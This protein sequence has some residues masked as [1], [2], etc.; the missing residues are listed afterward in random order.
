MKKVLLLLVALFVAYNLS[1]IVVD[2]S[3]ETPGHEKLA[4]EAQHKRVSQLIA[5]MLD[6]NHYN[7]IALNDSLSSEIFDR[8]LADLDY[9]KIY[10]LAS[11]V[12]SFEKYRD[13]FDDFIPSGYLQPAY[14]I[15]D[16]YEERVLNRLEYINK[17]LE[18]E[19]DFTKDEYY[20]I[21][22]DKAAWME[23]YAELDKEWDK[24]LK[25]EALRLKLAGKEWAEIV[26][27]LK[28]RYENIQRR[29]QQ[30]NSEDVFQIYMNAY[31]ESYD[32]HTSYFSPKN[33]EDFKIKMSLSLEGIGALLRTENEYTKIVEIIAGGPADKSKQLHPNDRIIGVGQDDSGEIVDVIGWRIDDVVEL[34]RGPKLSTVRLQ[35]LPASASAEDPPDTLKLVRDKIKLEDSAAK[36]DTLD[37]IHEG[38]PYTF[39][40]IAVPTFYHDYEARQNG[41]PNYK[42]TTRD[43]ARLIGELQSAN[44]DGIIIDLRGNGG[45]F[46][47]EAV[48]LTGLFIEDGPVV[49]VRDSYGK[50]KVE[51]D[52]DSRIIYDGPL[53][54]L[55]DRLSASASEIF[56]AAIQDYG[57]GVIVGSQTF[58][59]G[60]VQNAVDLNRYFRNS[61]VKLGQV[62]LTMAKFYRVNGGSTQHV[63]VI[64]DFDFPSRY[65]LM[66]I[67]ESAQ[68]NSLLW[69]QIR[70]VEY[71]HNLKLTDA[72][73]KNLKT[74]HQIRINE[75]EQY[76]ELLT[77]LDKFKAEKDE[78]RVSLNEEKR[79]AERK[80]KEADNEEAEE[81]LNGEMPPDHGKKNKK[82]DLVLEEGGHILGDM[83]RL[84]G[85]G[86]VR[87]GSRN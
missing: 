37:I 15:F 85:D 6:Q 21:D 64:P 86:K 3:A 71:A 8:Y 26:K 42:S 67:G 50:V 46:L 20:E 52:S 4:P 47:N 58:G 59:K 66:E 84:A 74:R 7:K 18:T 27:T 83:I 49:Q 22:P 43:V 62:K 28:K 41:D 31:C 1:G 17:R 25:Y 39:G 82:D 11:D 53:A 13:K 30:F 76:K 63:G 16:V 19:F 32:P 55:V 57:R 33:F 35:I 23:S 34:I 5:H 2:S 56:A 9:G 72:L 51:R 79:R 54:V 45:G 65:G 78:T 68:K 75:N 70:P 12:K 29:V 40:V 69:D 38:R 36:S 14:E 61:D 77:Q 24:R 87:T 10:F 44:V 60:T 48:D 81:E 73:L 80:Q